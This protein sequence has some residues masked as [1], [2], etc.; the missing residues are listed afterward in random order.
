MLEEARERLLYIEGMI[1]IF[2]KKDRNG[3]LYRK[4]F[5]LNPILRGPEM[6]FFS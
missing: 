1:R 2:T 5:K 3:L 6:D 4:Y